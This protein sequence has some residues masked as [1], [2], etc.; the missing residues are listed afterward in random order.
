MSILRPGRAL[1]AGAW[2]GLRSLSRSRLAQFL[3]I[4]GGIFALA[5]APIP[6]REIRLH[7]PE[8]R[9]IEKARA[10]QL[11]VAEL[12]E[13]ERRDV[14]TR[15]IED[16]VLYYEARRLGLDQDDGVV[17]QRLIQKLLFLT[18]ELAG[19]GE[20]P[21]E[22]ALRACFEAKAGSLQRPAVSHLQHVFAVEKATLDALRPQVVAWQKDAAPAMAEAL[23]PFGES[24][25]LRREVRGSLSEISAQY[26]DRFTA[27]LSTLAIGAWSE[28]LPSKFG[29]H[30]V[31]QLSYEP[32]RPATFAEAKGELALPCWME[33]RERAVAQFLTRTLPQYRVSLD[34]KPLPLPTPTRRV[35]VRSE[36]SGED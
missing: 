15:A 23:P 21:D 33:R 5:P 35:A 34:G 18:E 10:R 28:P 8:L 29:W 2:R 31:R 6:E 4:G 13:G 7:E 16:A 26:G 3:V 36:A 22:A 9:L 20:P 27:A 19:V 30:L 24:F 17:R 32:P 11:G 25:P 1:L 14:R 12:S